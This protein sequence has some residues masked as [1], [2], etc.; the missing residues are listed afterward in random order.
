MILELAKR[1]PALPFVPWQ[2]RSTSTRRI[3]ANGLRCG[4]SGIQG[5]RLGS[6]ELGVVQDPNTHDRMSMSY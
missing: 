2:A 4:L 5:S 3:F 6:Q 1:N